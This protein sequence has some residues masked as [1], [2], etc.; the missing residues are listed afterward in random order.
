MYSVVFLFF[1]E[2]SEKN[3]LPIVLDFLPKYSFGMSVVFFL[4]K[5]PKNSSSKFSR[6]SSSNYSKGFSRDYLKDFFSI[7][8]FFFRCFSRCTSSGYLQKLK[9]SHLILSIG[10]YCLNF[11]RDSC[12]TPHIQRFSL[13]FIQKF[14][15]KSHMILLEDLSGVS[16]KFLQ[17]FRQELFR[18]RS[19]FSSRIHSESFPVMLQKLLQILSQKFIQ[20]LLQNLFVGIFQEIPT[21]RKFSNSTRYSFMNSFI[22]GLFFFQ[23]FLKYFSNFPRFFYPHDYFY[24]FSSTSGIFVY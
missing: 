9:K 21:C 15:E 8:I 22:N 6:N 11:S 2:I 1:Q 18:I 5:F 17:V 13:E 7:W 12:I 20:I 24:F 3:R 23:K 19:D 16:Q 10:N 4:Q 14:L